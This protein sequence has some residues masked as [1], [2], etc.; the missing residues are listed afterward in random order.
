MK[1]FARIITF[2]VLLLTISNMGISEDKMDK[3]MSLP[4]GAK[5]PEA[6]LSDIAWLAGYWQGEGLGGVIEENWSPPLGNSMTGTFKLITEG[7]DAFYEFFIVTEEAQS[8]I[9]KLKHFN[10][11]MSGWE[12]KDD[13]V[14]FRLV[15]IDSTTACFDGLT[16][17]LLD[18][19]TLQIFLRMKHDDKTEEMELLLNRISP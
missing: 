14:T 3:T 18:D 6:N 19:E 12:E 4:E 13:Y 2:A 9:L 5:S 16:Y 15:K 11:D 8:L 10:P 17:S 1:L 7:Q